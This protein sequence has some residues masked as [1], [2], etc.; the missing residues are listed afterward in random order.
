MRAAL[1]LL[2][3]AV[4]LGAL[5][6]GLWWV[7]PLVQAGAPGSELV[8][9]AMWVIIGFAAWLLALNLGWHRFWGRRAVRRQRP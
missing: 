8:A 7:W 3:M 1:W 5:L 4:W 6:L 9:A 2:M